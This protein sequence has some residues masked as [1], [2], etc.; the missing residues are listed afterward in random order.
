LSGGI[1]LK[2]IIDQKGKLFG[3]INPID[4]GV[5]LLLL[6]LAIIILNHYLP[7]PLNL[8]ENQ[9]TVGFLAR[10]LPPYV[11]DSL[12]VGEVLFQNDY[13]SYLG[14]ITLKKTEP[15]ELM[16]PLDGKM[17]VSQSPRNV[18]LRLELTRRARIIISNGKN[19]I[20]FGRL[21]VR[22]GDS[23]QTHTRYTSL[24]GEIEYLKVKP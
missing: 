21:A 19:G 8:R 9:V 1:N 10:D 23:L 5:I 22:V 18:D 3:L 16:M 11:A 4:L 13:N 7:Q 20:Y 14:K 2:K 12:V 6:V 24:H 15:A 17:V